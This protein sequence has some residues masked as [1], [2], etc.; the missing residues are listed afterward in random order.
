MYNHQMKQA[1]NVTISNYKVNLFNSEFEKVKNTLNTKESVL[2]RLKKEILE[3]NK[4]LNK[5]TLLV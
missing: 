5:I 4:M 3:K 1:G 2:K